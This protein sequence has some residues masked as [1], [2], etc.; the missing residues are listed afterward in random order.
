MNF[1]SRFLLVRFCPVSGRNRA[2]FFYLI[3][4]RFGPGVISSGGGKSSAGIPSFSSCSCLRT[5]MLLARIQRET[6]TSPTSRARAISACDLPWRLSQIDSISC[7]VRSIWVR[8]FIDDITLFNGNSESG[9]LA[10]G[11]ETRQIAFKLDFDSS[12][13]SPS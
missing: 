5:G 11:S 2:G 10:E 12:I 13:Y 8:S 6:D 3:S 7:L 1:S 9:S 4:F